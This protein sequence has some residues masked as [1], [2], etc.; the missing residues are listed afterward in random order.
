MDDSKKRLAEKGKK[1]NFALDYVGLG[2]RIFP[3]K[4]GLKT[5]LTE[6]GLK[7]ATSAPETILIWWAKWPNANIAILCNGLL[8]LDFDGEQAE[9]TLNKLQNDNDPLPATWMIRTGGGTPD[10]PKARGLQ[11]VYKA[12][13]ELNIRPGAGIYGYNGLDVRANDSYIVAVGSVTKQAYETIKGSAAELAD[14]PEWL[15]NLAK[16]AKADYKPQ[17]YPETDGK[18][19]RGQHDAFLIS[20]AGTYRKRGDSEAVIA[21]KLAIDAERLD[22]QDPAKPYTEADFR[23]IAHSAARYA[24]GQPGGNGHKTENPFSADFANYHMT[25]TGNGE[26][27]AAAAR[28]KALFVYEFRNWIVYRGGQWVLDDTGYMRRLAVETFRDLFKNS[29]DAGMQDQKQREKLAKWF[30]QSENSRILTDSLTEAAAQEGMTIS[31]GAIDD[32]PWLLNVKNGT[33]N[34]KTGG[35]QLHDPADL[36]TQKIEVDWSPDAYSLEWEQFLITIFGNNAEL[37]DYIQRAVGYSLN[38]TQDERSF[39]FLHGIGRNGKSQFTGALRLVLGQYAAEAKPE[40]FMEKRFA[41]SGPDE[42]QAGLKGIRFLT[43]GE[44]KRGQTLDVGLI[45]RM[46]GG[47][48]IWHERKFQHGFNFRPSHKLWLSGNHEPRIKDSTDSIWD[49]LNKI[50][51]DQRISASAEIKAYGEKLAGQ[52]PEAILNW[53]IQGAIGWNKRQL[54][55]APDCVKVANEDYRAREDIIHDFIT[56]RL[57]SDAT[58]SVTVAET[59]TA[60]QVYCKDNDTEPIGKRTFNEA[61]RE[62]GYK[63]KRGNYNKVY[64]QGVTLLEEK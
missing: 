63:D 17:N 44:L 42:G 1:V 50:P 25:T 20:M 61:M 13:A 49:R 36:L 28:G 37:I 34:L 30:I 45:K 52:Y 18:I 59:Y 39:F 41:G 21:D 62:H 43:A 29:A 24:P 16:T 58:G 31:A 4:P 56:D 53:C 23:R 35:L 7:D 40:L 32:K 48:T 55:D 15:I 51:F 54:T 8:V 11:L 2:F 6:H 12:P 57:V 10:K 38:G 5:P 14:A 27:I 19:P 9:A 22:D 26:A 33:L 46:T 64:W 3:L 60:Y 47:E